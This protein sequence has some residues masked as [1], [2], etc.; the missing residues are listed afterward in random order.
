MNDSSLVLTR[1]E[2]NRLHSVYW[3]IQNQ[4]YADPDL[5]MK[6][7]LLPSCIT[8]TTLHC[9]SHGQQPLSWHLAGHEEPCEA[10]SCALRQEGSLG[11]Q[12]V[13][14]AHIRVWL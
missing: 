3:V 11:S 6:V 8:N 9:M 7:Y 12:P 4:T 5:L 13:V 10:T 14:Q 2:P 1:A